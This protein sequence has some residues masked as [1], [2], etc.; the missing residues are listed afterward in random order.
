MDTCICRNC[1]SACDPGWAS[2]RTD[3][4]GHD[5]CPTL[6]P[7]SCGPAIASKL[8]SRRGDLNAPSVDN[9]S[10]ALALSYTGL[11]Q[12]MHPYNF[13]RALTPSMIAR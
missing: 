8:W 13:F 12:P 5:F 9:G 2:N 6:S 11:F 1:G 3:D 10:T 7:R 4:A